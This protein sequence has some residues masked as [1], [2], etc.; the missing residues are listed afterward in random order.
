[1]FFF[2]FL[3][4]W[5]LITYVYDNAQTNLLEFVWY[6]MTGLVMALYYLLFQRLYFCSIMRENHIFLIQCMVLFKNVMHYNCSNSLWITCTLFLKPVLHWAPIICRMI[7][8][9]YALIFSLFSYWYIMIAMVANEI[10]LLSFG[11]VSQ[12][13]LNLFFKKLFNGSINM[14]KM[15]KTTYKQ[16]NSTIISLFRL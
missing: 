4:S 5:L 6:D 3:V 8:N 10:W 14:M 12:R 16:C 7:F 11:I 2:L 9:W 15:N 13:N 1:M